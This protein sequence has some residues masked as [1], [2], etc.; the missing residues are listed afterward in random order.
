MVLSALGFSVMGLFVKAA[1]E[2]G[3]P[4]IEIV[5]ARSLISLVLSYLA[6]RRLGVP[7]FGHQ[8]GLLLARGAVGFIALIC[9]YYALTHLPFAE[10][11]VLQYLHPMFTAV[12]AI[13]FLKE[14]LTPATVVCIVMSFIGLLV[15]ARPDSF[16]DFQHT[17]YETT[18]IL[19]AIAGA[20]GSG[21]AYVLV[22]K[23][24]ATE[25]ASVIVFYFPLV[26]LPATL[27]FVLQNFVMPEGMT[28][29]YLL[30]VGIFTQ[31]GQVALTKGMQ[32]ETASRATSFSYLQ[33]VFAILLGM[34]FF[35]EIP[36]LWTIAGA[37]MIV[38][39]SFIN[40]VWKPQVQEK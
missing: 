33:I 7:L 13:V 21:C 26:S 1:G 37:A 24:S 16:G 8:K 12:I 9:V 27:P 28:W 5:A 11:T 14:V 22:R 38:T 3:I 6:V 32:T 2:Q 17:H 10:A 23:L 35:S 19:A 30:G 15:I 34:L 4:V 20:F 40:A 39:G 29:F 25:S 31:L 18:A 36:D